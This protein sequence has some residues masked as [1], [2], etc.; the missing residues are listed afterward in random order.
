VLDENMNVVAIIGV[1]RDIT[2]RK[3]AEDALRENKLFLNTL[4]DAIPI[5]V[6]YKDRKGKY[7]GFNKAF[8]TS[9]G[10]T[11]EQLIGKTIFDINPSELAEIHCATDDEL[12][13]SGATQRYELKWKGWNG[14]LGDAIF[15]KAVFTDNQG[16]AKGIIGVILDIT[17]RKQA[18]EEKT[19]LNNQLQQAKKMETIGAI[20]GGIAHQFNNALSIITMGLDMIETDSA[21]NEN[22]ENHTHP[23]KDSALRMAKLASQLLAYA[24]GGKYQAKTISLNDF[25]KN[26]LPLSHLLDPDIEIKMDLTPDPLN[27]HAD[28]NQIKMLLSAILSNATE[29]M[30][31]KGH[32]LISTKKDEIDEDFIESHPGLKPGP[33]VCLIA[34]DNGKG[35]DKETIDRIFEPFFTTKFEGR[36]LGMAAAYGIVKNHDGW[37]SVDSELDKG[38]T[39]KIYLPSVEI[40]VK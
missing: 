1:G 33:Y 19:K 15:S 16:T 6:Y 27:I 21:G 14:E 11:K 29:A 24:R 26:T 38:T 3:Q 4:L 17:E 34:E 39:V 7:L 23:M 31:G 25:L 22:I 30:E 28:R 12:L 20:A 35:M 10:A 36:G 2:E 32:F 13:K 37:I 40:P 5:P 9:F 8:E 18:E